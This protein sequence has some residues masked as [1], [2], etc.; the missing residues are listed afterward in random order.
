MPNATNT[1]NLPSNVSQQILGTM[2]L[3]FKL[4]SPIIIPIIA[5]G[6]FGI[7]L[8]IIITRMRQLP[9]EPSGIKIGFL[10]RLAKQ[11]KL[12]AFLFA[13]LSAFSAWLSQQPLEFR[14][15]FLFPIEL[16]TGTIKSNAPL[17][18]LATTLLGIAAGAMFL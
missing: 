9:L 12:I 5:V 16:L 1:I 14:T 8:R 4:F 15:A 6:I 13:T 17:Y 2:L 18:V 10:S 3:V 11:K 7:T